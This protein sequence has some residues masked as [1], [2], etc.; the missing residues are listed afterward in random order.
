M[1]RKASR[2]GR[3]GIGEIKQKNVGLQ[4]KSLGYGDVAIFGLANDLKAGLVLQHVLDAE[5]HNRMI[6]SDHDTDWRCHGPGILR[7]LYCILHHTCSPDTQ[8]AR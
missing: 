1:A 7:L 5:T 4:F 8:L 2:P 3:R 6:V